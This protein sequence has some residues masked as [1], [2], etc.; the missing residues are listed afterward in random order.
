MADRSDMSSSTHGSDDTS[1]DS[2]NEMNDECSNGSQ[3]INNEV[4]VPRTT[5]SRSSEGRSS[6]SVSD[7][8]VS[9]SSTGRDV[10]EM[11][12][13]TSMACLVDKLN[14][15][16]SKCQSISLNDTSVSHPSDVPDCR[17]VQALVH[18]TTCSDPMS[19]ENFDRKCNLF[20]AMN[21]ESSDLD[22]NL[23]LDSRVADNTLPS[24][25]AF[26][27]DTHG[28]LEAVPSRNLSEEDITK[29]NR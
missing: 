1:S 28:V 7:K 19:A 23:V 12:N 6:E 14:L 18:E 11:K 24:E 15:S 16:S 5:C 17:E 9:P 26:M 21:C 3:E 2:A 29:E 27:S 10:L 8:C 22:V 13:E 4:L 20:G 25:E